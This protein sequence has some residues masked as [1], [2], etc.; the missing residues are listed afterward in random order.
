MTYIDLKVL[1]RRTARD[2]VLRDKAFNFAKYATYDGYQRRLA[3]I[4]YKFFDKKKLGGVA[5]LV[6]SE[7]LATRDLLLKIKMCQTKD[8]LKNF[9]NQ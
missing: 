9:I 2:K 3:S 4:V 6:W 8:Y 7:T 5:T 1:T